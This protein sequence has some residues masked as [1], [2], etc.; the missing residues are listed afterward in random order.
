MQCLAKARCG[1][2]YTL[3]HCANFRC[4]MSMLACSALAKVKMWEVFPE[5]EDGSLVWCDEFD[6]TGQLHVLD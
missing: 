2:L 3:S 1:G 4:G 6:Y 5:A